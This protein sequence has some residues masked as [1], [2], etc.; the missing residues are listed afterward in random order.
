MNYPNVLPQNP[1]NHLITTN[2]QLVQS[3]SSLTTNNA[4]FTNYLPLKI[5]KPP[6]NIHSQQAT[7]P[8]TSTS[9]IRNYPKILPKNSTTTTTTNNLT[10]NNLV[11]MTAPTPVPFMQNHFLI[12]TTVS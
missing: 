4:P 10:S 2:P 11:K 12:P 9:F 8:N 7:Q 6:E 5:I 3:P 1:I